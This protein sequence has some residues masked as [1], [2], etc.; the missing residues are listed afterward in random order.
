MPRLSHAVARQKDE[1]PRPAACAM[2]VNVP[3]ADDASTVSISLNSVGWV[4]ESNPAFRRGAS[5]RK[6]WRIL[7][8]SLS[9]KL[10]M[11]PM[12]ILRAN[13]LRATPR[14]TR[15]ACSGRLWKGVWLY[16]GMWPRRGKHLPNM[17]PS[18][19]HHLVWSHLQ[20]RASCVLMLPMP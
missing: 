17:I 15:T 10:A 3:T 8:D 6:A 12:L 11:W 20:A 7:T 5:V 16:W 19:C 9:V 14:C 2:L 13:P 4:F 1:E 18:R